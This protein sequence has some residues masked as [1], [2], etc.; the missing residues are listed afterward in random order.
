MTKPVKSLENLL[1]GIIDYAGLF[2]PAKLPLDEAFNNYCEY[3]KGE[4]S[5]MLS[6]FIIPA[7]KLDE[8]SALLRDSGVE[9][10][11]CSILGSSGE[12]PDL[13]LINL[14]SDLELW[15]RFLE[16]NKNVTGKVYEVKLP[17]E[18]LNSHDSIEITKFI[19]MVSDDIGQTIGND[20]T[21]FFEGL[22]DENWKDN[23]RFV[24]EGIKTHNL[25]YN[26]SGYKLRTGGVEAIA[27]PSPE[28][29]AYVIHECLIH[30]IPMKCTAGLHHPLRHFNDEVQTKMHGFLNIFGAGAIAIRHNIS[31]HEML[32][33][34]NEED[35]EAFQFSEDSLKWDNYI[36]SAKDIKYSR[37]ALIISYGS[38]SFTEPIE[39]LQNLNLLQ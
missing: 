19:E 28:Q 16:D 21:L 15:K 32:K 31:E 12:N 5:W 34:L 7:K 33:L 11:P 26:N 20:V 17:E 25:N 6:N 1:T 38:C 3:I 9:S 2:P 35:P 36:V 13:F 8:L 39:D 10:F 24:Q 14:K 29:V 18:I 23:V 37:E 27:F 4:F 22:L 30:Q